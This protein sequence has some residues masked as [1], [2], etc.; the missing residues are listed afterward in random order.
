MNQEA[1]KMIGL[2]TGYWLPRCIHAAAKLSLADHLEKLESKVEKE[3]GKNEG[4]QIEILAQEC[5]ASAEY[6]LRLMRALASEGIFEQ[7]GTRCFKNNSLSILLSQNHPH[8]LKNFA[9]FH[10]AS[11]HWQAWEVLGDTVSKGSPSFERKFGKTLFKYLEEK[12]SEQKIFDE[13]MTDLSKN[14]SVII[15]AMDFSSYK[16]VVDIGGGRGEFLLSLISQY[17]GMR[18]HLVELP[19]V[20]LNAQKKLCHNQ[21]YKQFSFFSASFFDHI[22]CDGDL[23]IMKYILHDF[24]D[25]QCQK[26]LQNIYQ[27]MRKNTFSMIDKRLLVIENILPED[28]TP[29]RGKWTD[30][31]MLALTPGG[32]ERTQ[33][34]WHELFTRGGFEIEEIITT[35]TP[36]RLIK[37]M[38]L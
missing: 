31:E 20:I 35:L 18:A 23:F 12:P 15:N 26:I 7:K 13:A 37:L 9:L 21:H 36:L 32:K 28:A 34:E 29:Y 22:P 25:H 17:P 24:D 8:G 2:I 11:W 30:L 10:E 38:P 6:L 27:V 14:F 5:E 1:L 19:H 3:S 16:E 33:N 4:I